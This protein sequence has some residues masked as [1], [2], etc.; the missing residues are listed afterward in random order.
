MNTNEVGHKSL[1]VVLLFVL[2]CNVDVY[3]HSITWS[4]RPSTYIR[5]AFLF[6]Q[7][8]KVRMYGTSLD[9]QWHLSPFSAHRSF[10]SFCLSILLCYCSTRVS[11]HNIIRLFLCLVKSC[12]VKTAKSSIVWMKKKCFKS[13]KTKWNILPI[14]CEW[15]TNFLLKKIKTKE[16]I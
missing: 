7:R 5:W 9:F 11:H 15:K 1:L 12:C 16:F 8:F 10:F 6:T 3:A 13:T 2:V 14:N 4:T